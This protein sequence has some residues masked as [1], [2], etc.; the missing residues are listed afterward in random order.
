MPR[1]SAAAPGGLIARSP[2]AGHTKYKSLRSPS[3]RSPGTRSDQW[4][5]SALGALQAALEWP[6]L[7]HVRPQTP[8]PFLAP[9][10]ASTEWYRAWYKSPRLTSPKY[11]S[12]QG[13]SNSRPSAPKADALPDCAMPRPVPPAAH[14]AD[15]GA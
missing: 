8:Q 7:I 13:D 3:R 14:S 2:H 11:W 10:T 5:I 15:C 9:H 12:G 1:S 4:R 6:L